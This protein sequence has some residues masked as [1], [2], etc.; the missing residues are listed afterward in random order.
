[1]K[2]R[3]SDGNQYPRRIVEGFKRGPKS[4]DA[5]MYKYNEKLMYLFKGVYVSVGS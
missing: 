3:D 4:V 5:V 1:M 2:E